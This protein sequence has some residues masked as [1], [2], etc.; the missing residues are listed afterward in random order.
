MAREL[1]Y[2]AIGVAVYRVHKDHNFSIIYNAP[3]KDT[4]L[5]LR[6]R[7]LIATMLALPDDWHYNLPGLAQQTSDG[8][9]MVK[10]ALAELRDLGYVHVRKV[11]IEKTGKYD[12]EY[13]IYESPIGPDPSR[14]SKRAK[15]SS[16]T[17]YEVQLSI[18]GLDPDSDNKGSKCEASPDTPSPHMESPDVVEPDMVGSTLLSTELLSTEKQRTEGQSTEKKISKGR[19]KKPFVPPTVEEV[20]QYC[21][22][23]GNGIDAQYFVD[24]YAANDW[25]DSKGDPVKSWKQRVL[26]WEGREKSREAKNKHQVGSWD[27]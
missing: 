21:E 1:R 17:P 2:E 13:D 23:R 11:R 3:L 19:R 7:G 22:E 8:V 14:Q 20:R 27:Y 5:S 25:H 16:A 9:Q 12:Y 6:A 24:Y 10:S 4:R 15:N 26:T 18:P